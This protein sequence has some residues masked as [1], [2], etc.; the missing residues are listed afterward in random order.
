M[1]RT[2]EEICLREYTGVYTTAFTDKPVS[3]KYRGVFE[4]AKRGKGFLNYA[5][6]FDPEIKLKEVVNLWKARFENK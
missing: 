1:K 4:L 5:A 6:A 2:L 3:M